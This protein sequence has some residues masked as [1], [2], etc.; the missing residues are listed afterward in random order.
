MLLVGDFT[1][2][3]CAHCEAR[4][5]ANE[6]GEGLNETRM[7]P[8]STLIILPVLGLLVAVLSIDAEIRY[9]ITSPLS[10]AQHCVENS[11]IYSV[12]YA[13]TSK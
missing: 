7:S 3:A 6:Q 10:L 1:L 13:S 4:G 8:V 11:D 12:F 9:A 5:S 2:W